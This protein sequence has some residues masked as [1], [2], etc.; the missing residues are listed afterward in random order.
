MGSL[1]TN[2]I[3]RRRF[4]QVSGAAAGTFGLGSALAAC[5]GSAAGAAGG[6]GGGTQPV[7]LA[8][9]HWPGFLYGVPWAVAIKDGIAKKAG[10][11]I[12]GIVGSTG[13]GTTVRSVVTGGLP[14]GGVATTG[15][16]KAFGAGA[17]LKIIG[18]AVQN[19]GEITYV[20]RKDSPVS[21]IEDLRGKKVGFTEEGSSTQ[22]VV[23]LALRAA[24]IDPKEVKLQP[25]GGVP[26][27]L[28]LLKKGAIDA[29]PTFLPLPMD[30]WKVVFPTTK[31]VPQ[32]MSVAL[33]AGQRPIEENPDQI[34]SLIEVYR[35]SVDVTVQHADKAVDAWTSV[36]EVSRDDASRSLNAIDRGSFYSVKL[37]VEALSKAVE[38]MRLTG[39]L[40]G[41]VDW[42]QLL[43]QRF[44]QDS[45][46]VDISALP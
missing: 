36:S 2:S 10:V 30:E 6:D 39:Q 18:G 32:F 33:V 23:L 29:A 22:A 4:L 27:G 14:V 9:T 43:D 37:T 5:G 28:T 45:E 1:S 34:R 40:S 19:T 20:T 25:T 24:G 38:S 15:A 46:K 17:G 44:L 13:G 35:R 12:S 16:I 7:R 8:V 42:D 11:P 41:K 3:S 26:E 21:S 31:Y